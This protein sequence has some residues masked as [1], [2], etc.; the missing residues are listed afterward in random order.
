MKNFSFTLIISIMLLAC[1]GTEQTNSTSVQLPASSFAEQYSMADFKL[2]DNYQYWE[3]RKGTDL[4]TAKV[5]HTVLNK[6]DPE[7][8]TALQNDLSNR[9]EAV[10]SDYG[11]D[12]QCLPSYCPIYGVAIRQDDIV[13][14]ESQQDLLVFF[15]YIDTE[16]EV[17]V[18]LNKNGAVPKSYEKNALGYKVLV[19]WD[20]LCG[21]HGE[22]LVQVF[23]DGTVEDIKELSE[24]QYDGCY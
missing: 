4:S 7:K 15:D 22:K 23:T 10:Q 20:D 11:F 18:Y 21:T 3:I 17:F 24:T 1:N 14:I 12:S 8:F 19:A 13:V 6:Y 5:G 9:I 2:N 16:A